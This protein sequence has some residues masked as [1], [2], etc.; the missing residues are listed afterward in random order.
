MCKQLL[1]LFLVLFINSISPSL[2]TVVEH[3]TQDWRLADIPLN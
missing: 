3:N 2:A 1:V